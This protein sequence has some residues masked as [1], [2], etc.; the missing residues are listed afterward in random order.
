LATVAAAR[1][2]APAARN[3]LDEVRRRLPA[4]H[5]FVDRLAAQVELD[6]GAPG[7]ALAQL[8]DALERSPASRALVH[9]RAQ[10]MLALRDYEAAVPFL[11]A[12]LEFYRSD[13]RLWGML[14]E[15]Q[16][17]LDRPAL[18]HRAAA[19]RFVLL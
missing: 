12:S 4:G 15:A 2:D 13:A 7:A 5:A 9:L 10:A 6:A 11:E 1:R 16:G 8:D 14:S 3:A 17:A 19:E 18:A